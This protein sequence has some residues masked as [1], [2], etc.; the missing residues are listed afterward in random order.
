MR[1]FSFILFLI[2]CFFSCETPSELQNKYDCSKHYYTNTTNTKD[3]NKHFELP[4]PTSWKTSLYYNNIQSEIFSADTTQQ[5]TKTYILETSFNNG[6]LTFDADYY[7]ETIA[8]LK[9]NQL[10]IIDSGHNPFQNKPSYWYIA[11]GVK[12]GFVYHR[13]YNVVLLSNNTY[14]TATVKIYG[15]SQV[16]QRICKSIALLKK[17]KFLQ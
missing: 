2:F 5:L 14:F 1:N 16:N 12:K 3:F 7:K 4:I 17:V 13:F 9:E 11:K 10:T 6:V 8:L 15:D